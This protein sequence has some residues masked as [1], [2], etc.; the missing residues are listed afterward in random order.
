MS[1]IKNLFKKETPEEKRVKAMSEI[2]DFVKTITWE[3]V[4][5]LMKRQPNDHILWGVKSLEEYQLRYEISSF[6]AINQCGDL[7]QVSFT[8][9]IIKDTTKG[10][11]INPEGTYFL[12]MRGR[13]YG[14]LGQYDKALSDLDKAIDLKPD[15]ADAFVERG[16]VKQKM[17]DLRG[18]E[19]DYNKGLKIDPSFMKQ[20]KHFMSQVQI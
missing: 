3:E 12:L 15:Y 16:Y 5:E 11:K 1:F 10:L 9:Q 8:E 13:S 2:N 17:G 4:Q 7:D 18:A 20:V 6:L 19:E 14:D